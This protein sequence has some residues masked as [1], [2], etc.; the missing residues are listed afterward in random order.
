MKF[1][2]PKSLLYKGQIYKL[3]T[4]AFLRFRGAVYQL[5]EAVMP[6]KAAEVKLRQLQ[7]AVERP[8]SAKLIN[9]GTWTPGEKGILTSVHQD[10]GLPMLVMWNPVTSEMIMSSDKDLDIYHHG[11]LFKKMRPQLKDY[12]F[13]HMR[14]WVRASVDQDKKEIALWPWQPLLEH[15]VYLQSPEDQ[16]Q[17]EAV[18]SKGN[19]AF[20][21]LIQELGSGDYT[22]RT[23]RV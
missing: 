12:P 10:G 11:A 14:D 13:P 7:R 23:H 15:V 2:H 16:K 4:P 19:P 21:R 1:K 5:V 6:A 20:E 22:F 18:H 17:M 3:E 9:A 8:P